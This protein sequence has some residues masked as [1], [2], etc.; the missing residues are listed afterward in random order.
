[1]T[2]QFADE[3]HAMQRACELAA[4][5]VGSVEPNPP[6]GAVVVD[7]NLRSLGEGFHEAF[8]TAH[9]EVN[10]LRQAGETTR[11]ATLFVTLEPCCHTGKT[12]PCTRAVIEAG[13]RKVVIGMRDP[14]PHA[15]GQ[16]IAELRQA[17]IQVEVGVLAAEAER[18]AAPFVK[19]VTTSLPYVHA[20]W[21]MTLDG[22]IA[23]RTGDSQWISNEASRRKV[24]ALRGRMD[25]IVVGRGTAMAD[26]PL[27]TARP[28]GP[29]TPV[30][31]VFDS[32][33]ELPTTSQLV[34]TAGDVPLLVVA[35]R[36][37]AAENIAKLTAAG[38]EVLTFDAACDVAETAHHPNPHALL[39]ELGRRNM[40]NVLIEGG[41]QLL[42]TFFD[43]QLIDECHIFV[44]PKI[45]GGADAIGPLS[46]RG[47]EQMAAAAVLIEPQIETVDGDIYVHGPLSTV[48]ID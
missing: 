24:H 36:S 37:A 13:I 8:G 2:E 19:R 12:P 43:Q 21:A 1:M 40:T 7:D 38:A 26:D 25:A 33:A 17:G 47:V 34:R 30:R 9:A 18:L 27:L 32:R 29:R 23:T 15:D 22:K 46:G 6:V 3:A 35:H 10:A 44:A 31:I 41:G 16:G 48:N 28:S 5:G 39:E 11:G 45:V 42:G 4:K 14:S 20:K